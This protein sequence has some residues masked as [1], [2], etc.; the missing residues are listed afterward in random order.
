MTLHIHTINL[1]VVNCYLLQGEKIILI[2]TGIPGQKIFIIRKL[3][4]TIVPPD[5][6]ELVLLTHGHIDHFG[7]AKSIQDLTGAKIAIHHLEKNWLEDGRSPVPPG[8][9]HLGKIVNWVGS[10]LPQVSIKPTCAD[11]LIGD[12]G[13][14]LQEYGIRGKI[15]HTP[16]HTRGS[17]SLLLE[18]GDAFVG[19]LAMSARFMRF[20][21]GLSIFADDP[22]LALSSLTKL[23][24]MGAKTI[25]PAHGKPFPAD[26]FRKI[27]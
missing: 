19:D 26:V 15:I 13:M 18:T 7:N 12:E 24:N 11:I 25:Y 16:G 27:P 17:V 2:D 23:L 21:P 6:L 22:N 5:K 14:S 3:K 20:R 4:K 9:T 10:G 8:R 1:G